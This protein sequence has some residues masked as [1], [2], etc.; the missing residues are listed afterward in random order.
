LAPLTV[1]AINEKAKSQSFCTVTYDSKF[2][3]FGYLKGNLYDANGKLIKK[4]KA[5]EI[6]DVSANSGGSLYEDNRAK[7]AGFQPIPYPYTVEYEYETIWHGSLFY[8]SFMPQDDENLAVEKATFRIEIPAN[9]ELRYKEMNVKEALTVSTAGDRKIYS[10]AFNNIP[11]REFEPYGPPLQT[12]VPTVF[13]GPGK[14]EMDGYSGNMR[15]WQDL[16]KWNYE[17]NKNRD[18][19]P[20]ATVAKLKDLVKEEKDTPAKINKLYTH[21]QNNTRYVAIQ[22]GIGGWQ[23]F[24]ATSVDKNGY[25]DCKALTNYMQA[26]LKAVGIDSYAALVKAGD[27]EADIRTDFPSSQFNHV[28]LSV[29]MPKDTIWLECTS[30][31]NPMGYLGDFT[32]GRHVLLVTPEGGKLVKTPVYRAQD[33]TQFRNVTVKLDTEGNAAAEAITTYRGVQQ[34]NASAVMQETT[35]KQKKWLYDHLTLSNF[36]INSFE[37]KA[38]KNRIPAVKEKVT[39]QARKYATVSGKRIFLNV[40][41]LNQNRHLLPKLENRQT[42]IVRR[43]S[44]L[45]SDTVQY[46]LPDGAF[47][48]EHLPEKVSVKSKFG[49]YTATITAGKNTLTYTRTLQ[50]NQGTYPPT[51]YAELVDFY[52]KVATADKMQVVLLG[53]KP[54]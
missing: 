46:Q 4:L 22:L 45:D 29:P 13:T 26:M 40:N 42:D 20:E 47:Q 32:G 35:E 21:L 36:D 38:Q 6:Q 31:L 16:G 14:F 19:L 10:W 23:T 39:L 30:Q 1:T 37:F 24:E 8:P 53:N 9:L 5:S 25:G 43:F 7:L 33:N 11:P 49:E 48:V 50:M 51:A 18:A 52:K 15:T 27:N 54:Q 2:F 34:D 3:K 17:L 28:I 12:L 41:M 44:Y